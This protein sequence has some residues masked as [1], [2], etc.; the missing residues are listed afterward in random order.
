MESGV[1]DPWIWPV[2]QL[3]AEGARWVEV[4]ESVGR[5]CAVELDNK[6]GVVERQWSWCWWWKCCC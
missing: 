5:E 6:E 1:V 2:G 4:G 3:I